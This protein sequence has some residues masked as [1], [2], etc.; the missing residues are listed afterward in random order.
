MCITSFPAG[1][2]AAAP[3]TAVGHE[4]HQNRDA[5]PRARVTGRAKQNALRLARC[6][7][8][9][10]TGGGAFDELTARGAIRYWPAALGVRTIARVRTARQPGMREAVPR[11]LLG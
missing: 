10:A 8:R 4:P 6:A 5:R 7:E 1:C 2:Y 11:L 3:R 9:R